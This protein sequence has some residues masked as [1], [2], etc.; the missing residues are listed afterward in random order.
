MFCVTF[1]S[2]LLITQHTI[3]S[4]QAKWKTPVSYWLKTIILNGYAVVDNQSPW[5]CK[6]TGHHTAEISVSWTWGLSAEDYHQVQFI[7]GLVII[8]LYFHLVG[9]EAASLFQEC[10]D[11]IHNIVQPQTGPQVAPREQRLRA[12]L[13]GT[14]EWG[15]HNAVNAELLGGHRLV[16][17]TL[18]LNLPHPDLM[19]PVWV[20]NL[21]ITSSL[22]TKYITELIP[23]KWRLQWGFGN[24]ALNNTFSLLF[25]LLLAV[26]DKTTCS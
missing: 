13:R 10:L 1:K 23:P 15:L 24:W 4:K 18:Q 21:P 19:V 6:R 16:W 8:Y 14:C 26:S 12:L 17:L 2:S 5:W 7:K 25:Y 11:H 9:G 22:L 20:L 3:Q